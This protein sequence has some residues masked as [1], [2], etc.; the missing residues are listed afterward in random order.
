[1]EWLLLLVWALLAL[2]PLVALSWPD[3]GLPVRRQR[4]VRALAIRR[5]RGP[6]G[7]SRGSQGQ[8]PGARAAFDRR[9]M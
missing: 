2:G 6:P 7:A 3:E 9:R 4:V 5:S 8:M 1:M